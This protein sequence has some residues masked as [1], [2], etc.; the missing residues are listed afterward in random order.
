VKAIAKIASS[1][2]DLVSVLEA[3]VM[4]ESKAVDEPLVTEVV[5]D[6]ASEVDESVLEDDAD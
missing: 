6:T 3:A 1:S 2:D 4:D 5:D